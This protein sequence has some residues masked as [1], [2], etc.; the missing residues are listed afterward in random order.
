M[1]FEGLKLF[2][3]KKN[4]IISAKIGEN[5]VIVVTVYSDNISEKFAKKMPSNFLFNKISK[6]YSN[7]KD[8]LEILNVSMVST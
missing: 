8:S 5:N 3:G 6:E 7:R 4:R 2:P 1:I